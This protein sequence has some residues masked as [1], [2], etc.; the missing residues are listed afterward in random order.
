MG[1][2]NQTLYDALRSLD[3]TGDSGFEGLIAKL[4][5]SL[6][7]RRFFLAKAGFQGGRDM[8][9]ESRYGNIIAV[10]CKK[11]LEN[12]ELKERELLGEIAQ[13]SRAFPDLDLWVLVAS[14]EVDSTLQ[15]SVNYEA[16][17]HGFE[18]FIIDTIEPDSKKPSSLSALCAHAPEIVLQFIRKNK[19]RTNLKPLK[20]T[21][22]TIKT[23][24]GYQQVIQELKNTFSSSTVGYDNWR[25]QQNT[26]LLEQFRSGRKSYAVFKQYINVLDES[27][28]KIEREHV[29]K[30]LSNWFHSWQKDH[31][32]LALVGGEGDGKTWATA[33]WFAKKLI[34]NDNFP[35][36]IFLTSTAVSSTTGVHELLANNHC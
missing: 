30:A 31:A 8:S 36:V 5:E 4:L 9:T 13:V 3:P 27:V 7:G 26:W 2:P 33:S 6:I 22:A 15:D 23:Q 18:A 19:P 24:P 34:T 10:E 21:L 32:F 25:H 1:N 35:S 11:Y 28:L 14:R 17:E 20:N 29:N 12:T 16:R